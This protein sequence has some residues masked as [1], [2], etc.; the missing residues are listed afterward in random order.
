VP[1][2]WDRLEALADAGRI[3]EGLA[4]LVGGIEQ[5]EAGWLRPKLLRVKGELFLLQSSAAVRET[6]EDLFRQALDAASR[7]KALSWELRAAMSLARLLHTQGRSADGLAI[8]QPVYERFTEGFDTADLKSVK[9][10]LAAL[11]QT[12]S[13]TTRDALAGRP[14]VRGRRRT[15]TRQILDDLNSIPSGLAH[16]PILNPG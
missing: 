13:R 2:P 16:R 11:G 8:L 14:P 4:V 9:G 15:P 7:D 5:S 12:S 1:T 10:L 6:A 3:A